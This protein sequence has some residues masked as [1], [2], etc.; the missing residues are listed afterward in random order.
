MSLFPTTLK[1]SDVADYLKRTFGDESA[2]QMTDA[3]IYRWINSA[4][5]EILIANKL[6]RTSA[7]TDLITGTEAYSFPTQNIQEVQ[8]IH[9]SGRKLEY[10]SFQEAE[11]YIMAADPGKISTGEP[12]IWYEWAGIF[13]LYPK[14][15]TS[16]TNGITI[17]Y[18]GSPVLVSTLNDS[19]SVPDSYFNRVVE[20]CLSQAYEMDEDAQNSQFKLGQ[21][22]SG[23]DAMANQENMPHADTYPRITIL[24]DD[25]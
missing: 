24:E 2:V 18:V 13:Y 5:R 22:S 25:L 8:S 20:F 15:D 17:Y 14:P 12:A 19:L 3:D 9:I 1:V 10:R 4:Q 6:L 11:D 16:I 21:F 7:T 23:L